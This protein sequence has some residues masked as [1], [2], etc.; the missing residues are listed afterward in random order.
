MNKKNIILA[1]L[2]AVVG[3]AFT[4]CDDDSTTE[5]KAVLCSVFQL[6]FEATDPAGQEIKVVSDGEWHLDHCSEWVSISP[7]TGTGTTFVTVK[8]TP[9]Y[10]DNKMQLPRRGELVLRG[11]SKMSEAQIVIR[12]AG[13]DYLGIPDYSIFELEMTPDESPVVMPGLTVFDES[14]SSLILT[15]GSQWLYAQGKP[16]GVARGDKGTMK[17]YKK[18]DALGAVY[19]TGEVFEK[20]GTEAITLPEPTIIENLAKF[21]G[22]ALQYVK[23]SGHIDNGRLYIEEDPESVSFIDTPEGTDMGALQ[24][25]IVDVTG[26]FSGVQGSVTR[27]VATSFVVTGKYQTVFWA[28]DFEWLEPW[29]SQKPAG[30]TVETNNPDAT[31]Q[32][33]GTNK[34]TVDG[35][36]LT[37]YQALLAR[38]YEFP[39]CCAPD[40]DPRAPEAQT[41]LQ[42]NYLKLGLTGYYSGV[43]LPPIDNI[44]AG[45]KLAMKFIWC[46]QRQGSGTWDATDLVIVVKNGDDEQQYLVPTYHFAKDEVYKWISAYVEMPG[47]VITKDTK[48]TIR[49]VDSQWPAASGALRWFIDNIKIVEV[50]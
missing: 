19:I 48:I 43:K 46:S 34:A 8:V 13:D 2:L 10:V 27:L 50:E 4:S 42:R 15:D 17:G 29:S 35:Q 47:A 49:N 41:Y 31:A 22:E 23:I 5:A 14:G 38:G 45:T 1:A 44:P 18:T 16:A 40:K 7:E 26:Y 30:Q 28:E 21:E 9:N 32:Q 6:N 33:L 39:I 20:T 11:G 12:Q 24:N 3:F 37:T 36:T 25:M